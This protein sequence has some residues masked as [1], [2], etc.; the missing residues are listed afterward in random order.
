[1]KVHL[2]VRGNV[3]LP[4][5]SVAGVDDLQTCEVDLVGLALWL[6]TDDG[7]VNLLAAHGD[8]ADFKP[9]PQSGPERTG[10]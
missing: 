4:S 9:S 8:L 6:E 2:R 5:G 3:L 1:M 10:S 7:R